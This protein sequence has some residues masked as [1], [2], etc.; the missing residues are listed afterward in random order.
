[1]ANRRVRV[2]RSVKVAGKWATMSEQKARKLRLPD[3]EGRWYIQWLRYI[4]PSRSVAIMEKFN[5]T[6]SGI[7]LAVVCGYLRK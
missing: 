2:V 1:M 4:R 3:I 5:A 6:F 7:C